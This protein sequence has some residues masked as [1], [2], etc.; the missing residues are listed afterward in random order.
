MTRPIAPSLALAACL[1]AA[2]VPWSA[3]APLA[4]QGQQ[5]TFTLPDP[6]PTPSPAP[7]GPADERAGVAIPPRAVPSAVPTASPAVRG[8]LSPPERIPQDVVILPPPEIAPP[9]AG[10]PSRAPVTALRAPSAAESA[11]A[12]PAPS[13]PSISPATP[14]QSATAPV[15]AVQTSG[16]TDPHG[17]DTS[18]TL[19][20]WWPLAAG[21]LGTLAL[22]GA[23]ALAWRR[24]KPR[25]LRLAAPAEGAAEAAPTPAAAPP[26]LDMTLEIIRATRSVMMFTLEYRITIANRSD[27]AVCDLALAAQIACARAGI[28]AGSNAASP[29]AA[30]AL[31]TIA[32]IGPH[33]TRSITGEVQMPLSAVTP[34]RQGNRPLFVPLVHVTLD[35]A[36]E[37]G[38][39]AVTTRSFVIGTPSA[40]GRIHP[41]PLDQP[42]GAIPGLVAQQVAVPPA[43]AAA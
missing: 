26:R 23:G 40:S 5:G 7:A 20:A 43:S 29:G 2:L 16:E 25:A 4:A 9:R 14:A 19:T 38:G 12:E 36:G 6:T 22:L 41:I 33:Q 3:A 30:Q 1:A 37:A 42:P 27:R 8:I 34:L 39:G 21:A 15:P 10:A 24:R 32:R 17:A 11:G 35:S 18:R 28:G 13:Q 31:D